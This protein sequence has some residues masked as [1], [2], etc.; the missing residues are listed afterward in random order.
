MLSVGITGGSSFTGRRL[1]PFLFDCFPAMIKKVVLLDVKPH[2]ELPKLLK[3]YGD[4]LVFTQCD[5]TNFEQMKVAM[6]GLTSIIHIASYGMSGIES[7]QTLKIMTINVHGT[8][9]IIK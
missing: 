7:L 2:D 6:K 9:N 8:Q 4:K 1:V 3:Q 5:I